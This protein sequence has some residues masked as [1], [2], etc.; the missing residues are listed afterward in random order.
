MSSTTSCSS[1]AAIVCSSRCSSRADQRDAPGMVD[2]LLAR[3][4]HLAAVCALG[5]DLERAA[6]QIA[7][8]RPGC[9]SRRWRSAPRRGRLVIALRTRRRTWL[10]L[11]DRSVDRSRAPVPKDEDDE[12]RAPKPRSVGACSAAISSDA[13]IA[14]AAHRAERRHASLTRL[15][16]AVRQA[17]SGSL[18]GA[19]SREQRPERRRL[20]QLPLPAAAP[21]SSSSAK[22]RLRL[23]RP[24]A[25]AGPPQRRRA[26]SAAP[27]SASGVSN[28]RRTTSCGATV[29]FQR[30]CLS[31]KATSYAPLPAE[32]SSCGA[33]PEGDRAARVAPVLAH[34]E[35]EVLALAD[36]RG[37]D[38]PRTAADEQ[39]HVGVPEAERREPR[40]APA[41]ARA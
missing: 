25:L 11:P 5:R 23:R 3:A 9:T 19:P 12:R 2:E 37:V 30:F 1:A 32:R 36:R 38:R 33:E 17:A 22:I 7:C 29:P 24:G 28:T 39:R 15:R 27:R 8:R 16:R 4:A 26:T 13:R 31:L 21:A 35:A 10:S 18:I 14:T 40:R 6:D 41:R 34:A 20:E